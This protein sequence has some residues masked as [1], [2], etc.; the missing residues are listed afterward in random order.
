MD[1]TRN[2]TRTR[3]GQSAGRDLALPLPVKYEPPRVVTHSAR[4]LEKASLV[5]N[6]CTSYI[7]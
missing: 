5:V 3:N 1:M 6:A 2:E 4:D 7:P